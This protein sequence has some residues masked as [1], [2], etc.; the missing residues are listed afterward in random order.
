MLRHACRV[1]AIVTVFHAT[2]AYAQAVPAASYITIDGLPVPTN[3]DVVIDYSER[4]YDNYNAVTTGSN[5]RFT[6]PTG[7]AG[8]Y[9]IDASTGFSENFP[10]L[11]DLAR[12]EVSTSTADTVT[13]SLPS[14]NGNVLSNLVVGGSTDLMLNEGDYIQ[15]IVQQTTGSTKVMRRQYSRVSIHFVTALQ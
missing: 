4:L 15:V 3:T 9:H 5:W 13:L 6:V 1:L 14:S 2:A 12:I 7:F 8:V 11:A 10:R